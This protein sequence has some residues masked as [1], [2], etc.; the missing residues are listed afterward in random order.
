MLVARSRGRS[1]D[2]TPPPELLQPLVASVRAAALK[3]G[4]QPTPD[5]G[6]AAA[7]ELQ[8]WLEERHADLRRMAGEVESFSATS[9]ELPLQWLAS[10]DIQLSL[11]CFLALLPADRLASVELLLHDME[12]LPG[13]AL[14]ALR[15][16]AFPNLRTLRLARQWVRHDKWTC[17]PDEDER[18]AVLADEAEGAMA[19]CGLTQLAQLSVDRSYVSCAVVDACCNL[20]ALT[21]LELKAHGE[22]FILH[23]T[24]GLSSLRALQQLSLS[25]CEPDCDSPFPPPSAFPALRWQQSMWSRRR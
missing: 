7:Q 19:L 18:S 5:G 25:S 23:G 22:N 8:H 11:S 12:P 10:D 17:W 24:H 15:P 6:A 21:S 3:D 9:W 4:G 14:H 20:T 13:H 16:Y 1:F 2:V